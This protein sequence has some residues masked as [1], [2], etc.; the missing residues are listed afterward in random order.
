MGAFVSYMMQVTLVM[1]MLYLVY[2]W[3][4]AST[5]FHRLNRMALL[6][7]YLLAWLLPGVV[8][9]GFSIKEGAGVAEVGFPVAIVY[10]GPDTPGA[11]S[12]FDWFRLM[13]WVYIGGVAVV[14]AYTLAGAVRMAKILR[15][16]TRRAMQGYIEIVTER[17]PGPFS[18]GRYVVLRPCDCD[19]SMPMVVEHELT[20]L[21]LWH[22]LDLVPAQLT[23][24]LQWYSP[25]AWLMLYELKECHEYEVD[26][27]VAGENP[28]AYQM[29]LIRKAVGS[30][31]P[32]F[33]DSLNHSQIKKRITMMMTKR[34]RPSR[35]AAALALPAVAALAVM[36]LSQ[37]AVADVMSR[38]SSATLSDVSD[39]KVSESLSTLQ[40]ADEFA[41]IPVEAGYAGS[42]ERAEA[43]E[44]VSSREVGPTEA[45]EEKT[46]A[47]EKNEVAGQKSVSDEKPVFFVDGKLHEGGIRDINPEDIS[48]MTIR[49]DDPAYPQG[50]V[51]IETKSAGDRPTLAPEKC[52]EFQ[53]GQS[54][55]IRFIA[56]NIKYPKDVEA[57]DKPVRV[58]VQFTVKTDGSIEDTK[59]LRG[60]GDAYD[61]EA[62]RVVKL[63]SGKWIPAEN[64]GKPVD[65]QFTIPL[66]FKQQ[67]K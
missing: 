66:T 53:G 10:A 12:G 65:S 32:T 44:D 41:D 1:S 36:A 19:E 7:I 52:A 21:R 67:S 47:R 33:A 26:R 60:Q 6:S 54:E 16:G 34:T 62:L 61:A 38:V 43:L 20:H 37:P 17:A 2:R 51:M 9:I 64:G 39:G 63:M 28:V 18:W 29:M 55:L 56:A 46:V 48:S 31:F 50:K 5:T 3:V 14:T 15:S 45:D 59:V 4:L 24:I 30:S 27:I 13:L 58:I 42:E 25:A 23:A 40:L 11:E 35:R 8:S 49:K 22:W 57:T